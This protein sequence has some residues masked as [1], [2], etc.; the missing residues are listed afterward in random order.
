VI[1]DDGSFRIEPVEVGDSPPLEC[2][3][4]LVGATSASA[5]RNPCAAL[6]TAIGLPEDSSV[7]VVIETYRERRETDITELLSAV[8]DELEEPWHPRFSRAS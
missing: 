1:G 5:R 6:A 3:L 8:R 4:H 7:T 2:A